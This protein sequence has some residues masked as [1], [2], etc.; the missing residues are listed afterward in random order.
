L[1]YLFRDPKFLVIL[2]Q[3]MLMPRP[4]RVTYP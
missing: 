2:L 4:E 1:G 3:T